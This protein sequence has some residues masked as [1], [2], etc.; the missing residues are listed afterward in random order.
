MKAVVKWAASH[1]DKKDVAQ[2][3]SFPEIKDDE[4]WYNDVEVVLSITGDDGKRWVTGNDG[5]Q[6][7]RKKEIN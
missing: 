6:L 1:E 7:E 2:K 4:E 5:K 3:Y